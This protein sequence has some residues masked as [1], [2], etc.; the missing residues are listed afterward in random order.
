M[1]KMSLHKPGTIDAV[2]PAYNAMPIVGTTISA[3]LEQQLPAGFSLTIT[4]VDDGSSDNTGEWLKE[5]FGARIL[6]VRHPSNKGRSA[7]CNTGAHQGQGQFLLFLDSDCVP[8][9]QRLI[10]EH[11]DTISGGAKISC[12]P[13]RS[14]QQGFWPEYQ[15]R[16]ADRRTRGLGTADAATAF[17]T[18][19]TIIERSC[20]DQAGGFNTCYTHYGFEDRDL[21][22]RLQQAGASVRYTPAAIVNHDAELNLETV[23]AKMRI[24][25]QYSS[26]KFAEQHPQSYRTMPY[27][28]IDMRLHPWLRVLS[29]VSSRALPYLIRCF[30]PLLDRNWLPMGLRSA[31]VRLASALAYLEGTRH[32]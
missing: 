1:P 24:S 4:V 9:N 28:R 26:R 27:S 17:T 3:L 10:L 5:H 22:L 29:P 2:I 13:I 12:G 6:V 19:N 16:L 8:A 20:F 23:C 30:E 18:A 15:C 25:G 11:I 14:E 7:T 31:L 32:S 21:L